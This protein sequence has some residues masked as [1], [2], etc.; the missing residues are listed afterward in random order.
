MNKFFINITKGLNLN[1][2][3]GSLSITIKDILKS[4]FFQPSIDKIRKTLKKSFL[5]SKEQRKT[6]EKLF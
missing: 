2:D 4:F 5:S 3:Q 6:C 1:E